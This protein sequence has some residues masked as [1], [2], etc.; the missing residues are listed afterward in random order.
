MTSSK[1]TANH[2]KS[3]VSKRPLPDI[4]VRLDKI[5]GGGQALGTLPDG[6]KVFVW[7]GLPGELVTVQLTKKKHSYAE[8]IVTEILQPSPERIMPRDADSFLSTS[9]W[10]IMAYEAEQRY[11]AA[12]IEEAFELH[13]ISLPSPVAVFTDDKQYAYRNKAEF[14]FWWDKERKELDLAFFKR[15]SHG[16]LPVSGTSLAMPAINQTATALRDVLRTRG[17]EAFSLKTALIRTSQTDSAVAQLYV[18]ETDFPL[19]TDTEIAGLGVEGFELIYSDPKSPASVITKRLQQWGHTVLTD[20]ILGVPF[21]YMAESF[22]QVNIPVYEQ[23]LRDIKEWVDPARPT[24]DLYSG[25]GSLGLT[26]AT[27]Q[28]TLVEINEAAVR[29]AGRTIRAIG[30]EKTAQAVLS[31]SENAL[32]YI[33]PE[34]TIIVDPP[35][36]GLHSAVATQLLSEKP[37]RIIYLSCNPA[38]QARDVAML[39]DTYTIRAHRGYN[40]FPRTPHIEHLMVLDSKEKGSLDAPLSPGVQ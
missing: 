6:P 11:K 13:R 25:V 35:R 22:F 9:P 31:P 33:T 7:G 8:G 28:L 40:F 27:G 23:A 10:Q 37:P 5:V 36:A 15:G 39:L 2:R 24:V 38:T 26:V 32:E 3:S 34:V 19:L 16:K 1:R 20:E 4:Q 14:S 29:E 17:G 21:T 18:K 12:L 30:R